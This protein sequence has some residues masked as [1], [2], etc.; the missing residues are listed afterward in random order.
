MDELAQEDLAN[1]LCRK[2]LLGILRHISQARMPESYCE[3]AS[4]SGTYLHYFVPQIPHLV[5]QQE[6]DLPE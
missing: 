6:E 3:A 2:D 5:P 4:G 1:L